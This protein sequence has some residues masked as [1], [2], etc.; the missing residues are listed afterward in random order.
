MLPVDENEKKI[1]GSWT[2]KEI[3]E[4]VEIILNEKGEATTP[5]FFMIESTISDRLFLKYSFLIHD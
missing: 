2:V 3:L 1:N 4:A 5:P